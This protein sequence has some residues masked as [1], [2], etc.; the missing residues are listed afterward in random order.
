MSL[1]INTTSEFL[2]QL[3]KLLEDN[4]IKPTLAGHVG[5]GNFHII[6]LMDLKDEAERNK[7]PLVLDQF[8][9]LVHKYKGTV[10]AE[11]NDGLIR[12]PFLEKQFG[13]KMNN[14][15]ENLLK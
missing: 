10:T 4:G 5:D 14:F 15:V 13:K 3:Y 8:T 7:I 9:T 6:P 11:H 1:R 2:P 12:T